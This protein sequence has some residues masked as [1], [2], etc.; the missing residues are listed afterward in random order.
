MQG[1]LQKLI[2][3]KSNF[4]KILQTAINIGLIDYS[5]NNISI[6]LHF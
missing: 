1:F 3:S 4:K 6:T 2:Y 5:L